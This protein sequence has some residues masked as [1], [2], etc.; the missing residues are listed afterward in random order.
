MDLDFYRLVLSLGVV[1]FFS[2]A[3][4]AMPFVRNADAISIRLPQLVFPLLGGITFLAIVSVKSSLAL[5]LGMVGALSIVRFRTPIKDPLE[6][7][8]LFFTIGVAVGCAADLLKQ[9]IVI[10]TLLLVSANVIYMLTSSKS[11]ISYGRTI[12]SVETSQLI[13]FS[14]ISSTLEDYGRVKLLSRSIVDGSERLV[15]E[16][17]LKS[18]NL[19]VTDELINRIQSVDETLNIDIVNNQL[20]A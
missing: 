19:N 10:A 15:I 13:N 16:L 8:L 18:S 11:Y 14:S 20:F 2:L 1:M 12:I 17:Y 7:I 4:V 3:L 6:L 5:S 9:T